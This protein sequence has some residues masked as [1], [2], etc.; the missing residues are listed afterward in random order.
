MRKLLFS[1]TIFWI[2]HI[3]GT[4]VLPVLRSSPLDRG[5]VPAGA[6]SVAGTAQP[7]AKKP[8]LPR[9]PRKVAASNEDGYLSAAPPRGLLYIFPG[10]G[11]LRKNA[12][13]N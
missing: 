1:W 4:A 12:S 10:A 13:A 3:H 5:A 7:R 2:F 11:T 8:D 9:Q 6:K